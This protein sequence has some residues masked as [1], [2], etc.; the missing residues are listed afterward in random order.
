[1][2]LIRRLQQRQCE[3]ADSVKDAVADKTSTNDVSSVDQSRRLSCVAMAP[4][5]CQHQQPAAAIAHANVVD[6]SLEVRF[7]ASTTRRVNGKISMWAATS[8]D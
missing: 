5:A 2:W 1:L 3:R 4:P 8:F 6:A 7:N